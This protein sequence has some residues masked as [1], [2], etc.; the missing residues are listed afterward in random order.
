[1]GLHSSR[2]GLGY[3]LR[4]RCSP[5]APSLQGCRDFWYRLLSPLPAAQPWHY[6]LKQISGRFGSS[7]LSYFLFLK[8]LLMFNIILF[9]I[10]LIFVV[11]LQAAYPPPSANPRPFTGL[12]LLTGAVSTASTSAP[13]HPSLG[14]ELLQARGP[15][16]HPLPQQCPSP[17][18]CTAECCG[19][20]V[21]PC[22]GLCAPAGWHSWARLGEEPQA[23]ARSPWAPSCTFPQG[24]FT[25]SLLYYGYYSNVTLNDPCASSPNGSMCPLAAPL[26]PY[27]MPLAYVFSVGVSFLITCILLVYR[28]VGSASGSASLPVAT[29]P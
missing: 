18:P 10:L 26:L 28:W 6:A 29:R 2:R 22:P 19:C 14:Q 5:Q 8:T 23:P 25:H 3:R 27:N 11:A 12:E 24:Y 4:P 9:L 17:C 13:A 16:L 1:M 7:V 21:L 20:P 15:A